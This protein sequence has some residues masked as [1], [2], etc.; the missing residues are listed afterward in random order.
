M[1]SQ[2]GKPSEMLAHHRLLPTHTPHND[3]RYEHPFLSTLSCT[4]LSTA[5]IFVHCGRT[6]ELHIVCMRALP[7]SLGVPTGAGNLHHVRRHEAPYAHAGRCRGEGT[8]DLSSNLR[9]LD[10][11]AS[12]PRDLEAKYVDQHRRGSSWIAGNAWFR[13]RTFAMPECH[14][15]IH[16]RR[17][18][19]N[20]PI[21]SGTATAACIPHTL[22]TF[23]SLVPCFFLDRSTQA[24]FDLRNVLCTVEGAPSHS[25]SLID[26]TI[27]MGHR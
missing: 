27:D 13:W 14:Q 1:V 4:S 19:I 15:L 3:P 11:S 23:A 6:F 17:R 10:E 12:P 8:R 16:I 9:C 21:V 25:F 24:P 26:V 7:P 20:M 22:H 2:L 18:G 5:R